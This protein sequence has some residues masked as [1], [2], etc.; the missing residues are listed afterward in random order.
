MSHRQSPSP[1]TD[2]E[3]TLSPWEVDVLDMTHDG[4]V[5][6]NHGS[7]IAMDHGSGVIMA[8]WD[9]QLPMTLGACPASSLQAPQ[10]TT[11]AQS[12]Y[13]S[14]GLFDSALDSVLEGG[15]V[16]GIIKD[17]PAHSNGRAIDD[18]LAHSDDK[19]I[20]DSPP[21]NNDKAIDKN[22]AQRTKTLP[23]ETH[24]LCRPWDRHLIAQFAVEARDHHARNAPLPLHLVP[25][26]RF[27]IWHALASNAAVLGMESAWLYYD[28][29]SPFNKAGPRLGPA[30]LPAA[31][32]AS[33]RLVPLQPRVE[34]HPW[35][36]L[37]PFPV[38]RANFLRQIMLFGEDSID[39]DDL[40]RDIVQG[41]VGADVAV[42]DAATLLVWGAS[43]DPMGWEATVPFLRKW[44]WL[45]AGSTDILA[46]TNYWRRQRGETQLRF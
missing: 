8:T 22:T 4:D 7:D 9:Q 30:A 24:S 31:C 3:P 45:F 37:L 25:V 20:K 46:S 13:H 15:I 32:P 1:S 16:Q 38:L 28:A 42:T 33:L 23:P 34:H 27:N 39:E 11:G 5:D 2:H 35:I 18:S 19:T 43:W 40:C 17:S 14:R 12:P 10:L 29:I 41:A 26:I 36:D 6:V 44:A 21:H